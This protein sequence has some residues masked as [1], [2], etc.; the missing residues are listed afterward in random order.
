MKR[1]AGRP[2][3]DGAKNVTARISA[4]IT[5]EHKAMLDFLAVACGGI[6]PWLR[7]AIETHYTTMKASK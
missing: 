6:S 2:S 1:K 7:K 5:P 4:V 3:S